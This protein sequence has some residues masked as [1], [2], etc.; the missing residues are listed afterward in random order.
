MFRFSYMSPARRLPDVCE[1]HPDNSLIIF[2]EKRQRICFKPQARKRRDA[3]LQMQEIRT[4]IEWRPIRTSGERA[5]SSAP[6][7][8][9]SFVVR[10]LATG[11]ATDLL[12]PTAER[13]RLCCAANANAEKKRLSYEGYGCQPIIIGNPVF[14]AFPYTARQGEG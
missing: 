14:R 1:R 4:G 5:L 3:Q 13:A 11:A 9:V 7:G 12:P 8:G 10:P 6:L 2:L